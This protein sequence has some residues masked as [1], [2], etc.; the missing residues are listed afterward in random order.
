MKKI[1]KIL[2]SIILIAL[3][4]FAGIKA[5]SRGRDDKGNLEVSTNLGIE[6]LAQP[7]MQNYQLITSMPGKG[8][9]VYGKK[10]QGKPYFD[11]VLIKT[12]RAQREFNWKATLKDPRLFIGDITGSGQDS[13]VLIFITAY[14][15]GFI[16][17]K[18]H[19]VDMPLTKEIPVED[20]SLAARRLIT[21]NVVGQEIVF[22][23]GGR[24][25][26]VKPKVGAAGIQRELANL[27]YGS[28]VNYGVE[29]N[30]LRSTVTVETPYNI[31]LGEFTLE[32]NYKDGKLVPEVVNFISLG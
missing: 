30:K 17:S 29:N 32:Y 25:Y 18:V 15:T 22:K 16:D 28:I 4:V 11:E 27:Y 26:R 8:V 31:F 6:E 2:G 21:A 20:P 13:I 24:E 19:V 5:P 14:G 9:Y 7:D 1:Y 12:P 3:F 10:L 23:T